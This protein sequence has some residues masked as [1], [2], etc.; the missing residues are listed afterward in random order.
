MEESSRF[1][2]I[3][4]DPT[5]YLLGNSTRGISDKVIKLS[6]D[7]P[8]QHIRP[9]CVGSSLGLLFR[10]PTFKSLHQ[11]LLFVTSVRI[12]ASDHNPLGLLSA[13]VGASS[14]STSNQ[15][16]GRCCPRLESRTQRKCAR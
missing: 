9:S 8:D 12:V 6:T 3:Y 5:S 1:D 13:T 7:Q 4:S 14:F 15:S 10:P 16:H 2:L 11:R